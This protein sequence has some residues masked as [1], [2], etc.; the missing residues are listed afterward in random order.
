MHAN[1]GG[2]GGPSE[3]RLTG[4]RCGDPAKKKKKKNSPQLK[5]FV[6]TVFFHQNMNQSSLHEFSLYT[7]IW[8]VFFFFFF[9]FSFGGGGGGGRV[10]KSPRLSPV[11]SFGPFLF[12]IL[13]FIFFGGGGGV[14]G[15][16]GREV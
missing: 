8:A 9:F 5:L 1:Q 10:Y 2:R 16:G 12:K 3:G 14:G 11:R 6:K 4:E 13:N 15:W 7:F